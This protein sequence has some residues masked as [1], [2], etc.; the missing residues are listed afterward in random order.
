[1]KYYFYSAEFRSTEFERDI[2]ISDVIE[3]PDQWTPAQAYAKL[4]K[5]LAADGMIGTITV[6]A[7]NRVE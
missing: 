2:V 4:G 6:R 1:M 3:V 5:D 7:F